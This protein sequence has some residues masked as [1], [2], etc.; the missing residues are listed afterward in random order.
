MIGGVGMGQDD[1]DLLDYSMDSEEGG[2]KDGDESILDG[3]GDD[4]SMDTA[5]RQESQEGQ[6][7]FLRIKAGEYGSREEDVFMTPAEAKEM[8]E[9]QRRDRRQK[10][11][12]RKDREKA[13]RLAA[14]QE[15]VKADA[16]KLLAEAEEMKK[17]EIKK[18]EDNLRVLRDENLRA[19]ME[20]K[21]RVE[22]EEGREAMRHR[23][24]EGRNRGASRV[25][26]DHRYY[27]V[28]SIREGR[29]TGRELN[30]EAAGSVY[31]EAC[32]G[33]LGEDERWLRNY[34]IHNMEKQVNI[35]CSFNPRNWL[36]YTCFGEPHGARVGR[37][38]QPVTFVLADQAFPAN[39][40]AT[41]GGE[42]FRIP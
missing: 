33:F 27:A 10:A 42:C 16:L 30:K 28:R 20:E 11:E 5:D 24:E 4:E 35:S 18:M 39:V 32:G 1:S 14:K 21:R 6:E 17:E 9:K 23:K 25:K 41:D 13:E 19:E 31:V 22:E 7:T 37:E 29:S 8:E 26:V 3:N 36:C 38:D 15:Q 34:N 12:D 2:V 40:P